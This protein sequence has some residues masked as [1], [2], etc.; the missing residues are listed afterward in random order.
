MKQ[1]LI[2]MLITAASSASAQSLDQ[3][4]AA[5]DKAKADLARA[6]SAF[7][8]A[9]EAYIKALGTGAGKPVAPP[10]PTPAPVAPKPPPDPS[11]RTVTF[12]FT[13]LRLNNSTFYSARLIADGEVGPPTSLDGALSVNVSAKATRSLT[14]MVT[15]RVF[16]GMDAG[17]KN[18]CAGNLP[19]KEKIAIT[20]TANECKVQ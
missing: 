1:L 2:L 3:L 12:T 18:V 17:T 11:V 9:D 13:G 10:T 4:R 5:R 7:D 8:Q 19:L 6:Q 15:R 14:Y 16:G 20:Y